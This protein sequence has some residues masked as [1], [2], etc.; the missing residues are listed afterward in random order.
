MNNSEGSAGIL[1][2]LKRRKQ[3]SKE[4][5]EKNNTSL[6]EKNFSSLSPDSEPAKKE[7]TKKERHSRLD[8]AGFEI[9]RSY[10]LTVSANKK[11]QEIKMN[12]SDP[13]VTFNELVDEAINLLHQQRGR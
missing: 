3:T 12:D 11:L 13:S 6:I 8:G 4:E 1:D 5:E 9:K 10:T 2:G 7:G